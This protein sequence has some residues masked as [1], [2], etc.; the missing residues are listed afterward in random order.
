MSR[1]AAR[2]TFHAGRATVRFEEG[3]LSSERVGVI[4]LGAIGAWLEKGAEFRRNL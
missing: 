4:G 2:A 1:R 3:F